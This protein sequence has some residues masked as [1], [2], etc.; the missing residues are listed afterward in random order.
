MT[1]EGP[2]K[3][4]FLFAWIVPVLQRGGAGRFA[5]FIAVDPAIESTNHVPT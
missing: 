5:R 1:P 4:A 3:R 2:H